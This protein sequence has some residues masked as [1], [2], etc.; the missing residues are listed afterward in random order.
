M[1]GMDRQSK[2]KQNKELVLVEGAGYLDV[3]GS[4]L[5]A[6]GGDKVVEW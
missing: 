6:C 2:I 4:F 1:G 5:W 3:G